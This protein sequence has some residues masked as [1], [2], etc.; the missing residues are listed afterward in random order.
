MNVCS[1]KFDALYKFFTD[2]CFHL[3]EFAVFLETYESVCAFFFCTDEETGRCVSGFRVSIR[4]RWNYENNVSAVVCY[5]STGKSTFTT[6]QLVASLPAAAG[7]F[8]AIHT[9][10]SILSANITFIVY[11]RF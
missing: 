8:A 4:R 7:H 6:G 11:G 9:P 5:V 1:A 2:T 3:H 10:M